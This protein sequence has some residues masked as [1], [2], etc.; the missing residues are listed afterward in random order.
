MIT[1]TTGDLYVRANYQ[2]F[3]RLQ[4]VD[5]AIAADGEATLPSLIEAVKR[6]STG[7]RKR[8]FQERGT[9]LAEASRADAE[10]A[11]IDA[12]YA[13]DA[14]PVSTARL[15][16]G[17]LGADQE[18]RLV[19][20]LELLHERSGRLAAAAVELRQAV[21]VLGRAGGRRNRLRR[22]RVGRRGAREQESTAG[23]RLPSKPTAT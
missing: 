6:L 11:R 12:S 4:D 21:P 14:S 17:A 1:I 16:G 10:R 8:V 5:I 23:S 9:K 13:W 7:D 19:A 2:D 22:A 3:R 15:S 18:R 20:R